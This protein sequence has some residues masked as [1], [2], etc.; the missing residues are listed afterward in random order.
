MAVIAV[1]DDDY[2]MWLRC[3]RCLNPAVSSLGVTTPGARPFSVP[4]GLP[5]EEDGIWE[6]VR[7]CLSVGAY[8]AAVTMCRKLL[9][10]LAVA[11]KLSP[12]NAKGHAPSFLE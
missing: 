5:P 10:H 1:A 8:T 3:A 9:L 12:K 4:E 11:N 6:E 2:Q 7:G